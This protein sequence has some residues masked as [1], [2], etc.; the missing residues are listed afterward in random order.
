MRYY[1]IPIF[2]P[3][4]GCPHDCVFCNQHVITGADDTV[5]AADVTRLIAQYLETI[6]PGQTHIEA[7]FFG[8][9]FTGIDGALQEE[10]LGAAHAFL[11]DGRI[12]GIRCSTRPDYIDDIVFERL[13]RYGVSTVELGVQSTDETVLRLSGRGHGRQVVVDAAAAIQA[14]GIS[15][16][17]QMMLGLP[18]DTAEKTMQTARDLIAMRPDCVRIY[19]TLVLPGTTL[20]DWY[21]AGK[22]A[23]LTVEAAV[24][25]CAALL[26]LFH[27]NGIRVIRVGLQTTDGVNAETA[28]G[29]Y[30]PA[31]R[32]LSEGRLFRFAL[33]K[34]V[35]QGFA[36]NGLLTVQVRPQDVSRTVGHKRE[37]AHV[38]AQRYGVRLKVLSDCAMCE[39]KLA[40][41]Y[42]NQRHLLPID[43]LFVTINK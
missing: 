12:D 5:R 40:V 22:F 33:E 1:R 17:L 37:N 9:S 39:G 26:A 3:H 32:E 36:E 43:G 28:I 30:H 34:A 10:L 23:P 15:L 25:Q 24:E 18:G 41:V 19:P 4:R 7:A 14:A 31:L 11:A 6:R 8:G 20:Y 27:Q 13:K 2:V 21:Q 16:G 29:P 38:L 35:E 42:K